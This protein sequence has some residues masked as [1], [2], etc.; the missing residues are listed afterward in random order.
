MLEAEGGGGVATEEDSGRIGAG[1]PIANDV[2]AF[3]ST[4]GVELR[5]PSTALPP[6]PLVARTTGTKV[7]IPADAAAALRVA[8]AGVG[9]V[10]RTDG[11]GGDGGEAAPESVS[12][13]CWC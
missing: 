2:A 4:V 3:S 7:V 9:V 1:D 5:V 11:E 12:V 6:P 8:V 10:P 13:V